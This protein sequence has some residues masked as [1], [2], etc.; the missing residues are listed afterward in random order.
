MSIGLI[1]GG[2]RFLVSPE[3]MEHFQWID[4]DWPEG[5]DVYRRE[6]ETRFDAAR[7]DKSGTV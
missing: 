2:V 5:D 7:L 1:R 3:V 4:L 6:M